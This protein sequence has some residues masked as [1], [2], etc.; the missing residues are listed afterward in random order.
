MLC[1]YYDIHT[2]DVFDKLFGPLYIGKHPT[3]SRNQYLVLRFDLSTIDVNNLR[4]SFNDVIN[5]VLCDFLNKYDEELDYPDRNDVMKPDDATASL[6]RV[7]VSTVILYFSNLLRLLL[8]LYDTK[9]CVSKQGYTL[10][11]GV[12]EYDAPGN[13]CAFVP[14]INNEVIAEV[15]KVEAFFNT[16]FF[17]V[18]KEGCGGVDVPVISKLFVTGVTPAFHGGISSFLVADDISN[19]RD[20]H[21]MCGFT[22]TEVTAMVEEYLERDILETSDIVERMRRLYNGYR[23]CSDD[24]LDTLYNPQMVFHFLQAYR[25]CNAVMKPSEVSSITSSRLLAHIAHKGAFSMHDLIDLIT[26]GYVNTRIG[27]VIN[28]ND[29]LLVKTARSAWS[30]LFYCGILTLGEPGQLKIPNEVMRNEVLKRIADYIR[31]NESF[32]DQMRP[33][34]EHLMKGHIKP[35][36]DLLETYMTSRA[37]VSLWSTNEN[38]IQTALQILL[39]L[40]SHRVP[41]LTLVVDGTKPKGSGRFGFIDLFIPANGKGASVIL[42]LKYITLAGLLKGEVRNWNRR[43][44]TN[45]LEALDDKLANKDTSCESILDMPYMYWSKE[46]REP[47]LTTVFDIYTKGIGQLKTYVETVTLGR[48]AQPNGSGVVDARVA[49]AR[50]SSGLDAYVIIMLGTRYYIIHSEKRMINWVYSST[51]M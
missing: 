19:R 3:E 39:D 9:S 29:L 6:Q 10:F 46:K 17:A 45:E 31:A 22:Q 47:V 33:A 1:A 26:T 44:E 27:Y 21:G 11:V 35:L 36:M 48:V 38:E 8:T 34:Y 50:G 28:F 43:I 25:S 24:T 32:G 16:S 13:N 4:A 40:T 12:D 18:I 49:A 5:H 14:A 15:Y 23:F 7:F 20:L 2:A 30:F 42:E 37:A 51:E 41:Q